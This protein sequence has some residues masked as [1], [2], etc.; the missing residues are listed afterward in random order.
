MNNIFTEIIDWVKSKPKFWQKAIYKLITQNSLNDYDIDELV[1]I[2]K[3]EVGLIKKE[4]EEID[5]DALKSAFNSTTSHDKITISKIKDVRNIKA[6]KEGEELEFNENGITVIYGDNGSGKSS[7]S[8]ILKHVCK[9]RGN[10]PNLG[11]NIYNSRSDDI[12]QKA[13]VE[14][15]SNDMEVKT[16]QWEDGVINGF[17]LKVVDVFDTDSANHY[18]TNED[19]VAFLPTGLIILEKLAICCQKVEIKLNSELKTLNLKRY[20]YSHLLEPETEISKFLNNIN[21]STTLED[22]REVSKFNDQ[23]EINLKKLE[24]ELEKLKKI[25]PTKTIAENKKKIERFNSLKN[26][27]EKLEKNFSNEIIQ[28]IEKYLTEKNTLTKA[29]DEITKNTFSDLPIEGIGNSTWKQLWESARKFI[30]EIKGEN[31][32]PET[33]E[34]AICPLCLQDL[35]DDAKKR[36]INFEKFVKQD[37]QDKLNKVEAELSKIYSF[38]N[39]WDIN[40]EPYNS[41]LKEVYD[42]SEDFEEFH[43]TFIDE[44]RLLKE[45][46]LL[47]ISKSDS[48]ELK[49]AYIKV[50]LSNKVS[51]FIENIK[52]QNEELEKQQVEKEII[53]KVKQIEELK[54]RKNL[55]AHRP[56]I[57]REIC[58]LRIMHLLQNAVSNCNT[59][60]ITLFSNNLSDKYVTIRLQNN[61]KEELKKLGFNYVDIKPQT[62]GVRGKQYFYLQLGEDYNTSTGLKDILSEGEHRAISL[63]TFFSELSIAEHNSSIVFDDPVSSLDHKWRNRI[64]KRI[65]EEANKRQIIIFTHDI[66]FLMMLQEH[67][68]KKSVSLTINSLTRKR[69]ETGIVAENPPWDALNVKKRIGFLKNELQRLDKISRNETEEKY[70]DEV[71]IFYGKLRETWERV[72]EELIL[73]NTVTRFGR[74]IQTQRLKK[75]V[76]LTEDDYKIIDENMSKASIYFTGHDTAGELIEE[77]PNIDEVHND[78]NILDNYVKD[79]RK[80]R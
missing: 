64:A 19:E 29:I 3:I 21:Y 39:N 70:K 10:L 13:D 55:K 41:T 43:N 80:R 20:D 14:Y 54:A 2:C 76:D 62:K 61:F 63:A 48:N 18:I 1:E 34:N 26:K 56:K 67:G 47:A 53:I 23:D 7:Y 40:F 17:D 25:D 16:I 73:N 27:Y 50:T 9:T 44:V 75:V 37:I 78:M 4:V 33:N 28:K 32:F 77:Y 66:T 22:L 38:Y 8:G 71:K 31:T 36:F 42:I 46:I 51:N 72:V 6:L 59:R 65:T 60:S 30:D 58:R 49:D 68:D 35:N 45:N 69:K 24:A 5:L 12:P 11:K 74:A 15:K 57:A 79:L 52:K